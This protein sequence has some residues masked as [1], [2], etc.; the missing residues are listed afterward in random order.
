MSGTAVVRCRKRF[1]VPKLYFVYREWAKRRLEEQK[2]QGCDPALLLFEAQHKTQ[3]ALFHFF[4]L[5]SARNTAVPKRLVLEVS[6][7]AGIVKVTALVLKWCNKNLSF[8]DLDVYAC[9]VVKGYEV[10][11][12]SH[13]SL[14]L[15][16]LIDNMNV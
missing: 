4:V 10:A 16:A 12:G 14:N 5:R 1:F 6:I 2:K 9:E 15:E 8:A 3:P 7:L 11:G 13:F